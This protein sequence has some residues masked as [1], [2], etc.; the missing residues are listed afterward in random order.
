MT[1]STAN[2]LESFLHGFTGAG[3][4]RKLNYPGAPT[5]FVDSRSLAEI[6]ATGETDRTIENYRKAKKNKLEDEGRRKRDAEQ[7]EAAAR[8]TVQR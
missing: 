6:R 8:R 7:R 3:L 2:I 5:E 1:R 4:F